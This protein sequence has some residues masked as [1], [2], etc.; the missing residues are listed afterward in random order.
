MVIVT[1]SLLPQVFKR[2]EGG[3]HGEHSGRGVRLCGQTL[4]CELTPGMP[5][6]LSLLCGTGCHRRHSEVDA[7]VRF[8]VGASLALHF[9]H[10]SIVDL[11]VGE[12]KPFQQLKDYVSR[13]I[14]AG[15]QAVN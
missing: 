6:Y 10:T 13:G 7:R 15:E 12:S 4:R 8:A 1:R 2:R 11:G 14:S 9:E 5:C 3:L